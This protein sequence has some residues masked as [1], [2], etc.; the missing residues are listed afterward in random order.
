MENDKGVPCGTI[1]VPVGTIT[2]AWRDGS[3]VFAELK[4]GD[5]Y[6]GT[7]VIATRNFA[8]G[9]TLS[10]NSLDQIAVSAVGM[11]VRRGG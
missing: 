6:L 2:K 5:V 4:K 11:E 9:M 8:P 10:E 3:K 1:D 7:V